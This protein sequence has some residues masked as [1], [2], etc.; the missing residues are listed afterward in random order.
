MTQTRFQKEGSRKSDEEEAAEKKIASVSL[1]NREAC[2]IRPLV[3]GGHVLNVPG[4]R[5]LGEHASTH[6]TE[7]FLSYQTR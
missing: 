6:A 4:F 5:C 1:E 7:A 3:C 2:L